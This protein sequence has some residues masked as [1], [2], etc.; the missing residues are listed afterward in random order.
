MFQQPDASWFYPD[1][2]T[3]MFFRRARCHVLERITVA[4]HRHIW[5]RLALQARVARKP[6]GRLFI[7]ITLGICRRVKKTLHDLT[8][9]LVAGLVTHCKR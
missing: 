2:V 3:E 1:A 4:V 7:A 6:F 5:A 9:N 8:A